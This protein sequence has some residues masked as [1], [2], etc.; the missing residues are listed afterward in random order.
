MDTA[1]R[2]TQ[3]LDAD[4]FLR[5]DQSAFGHAWRYELVR[6]RIVAHIVMS[7]EAC[8]GGVGIRGFARG[9]K[10]SRGWSGRSRGRP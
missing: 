6:G 7:G 10:T 4:A 2:N 3:L 8:A 9:T 1:A 5:T